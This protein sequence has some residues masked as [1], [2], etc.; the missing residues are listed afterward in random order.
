MSI[1]RA[2]SAI[3]HPLGPGRPADRR[4]AAVMRVRLAPWRQPEGWAW[5]RS[6]ARLE[7]DV[8]NEGG[9]RREARAAGVTRR[10]RTVRAWMVPQRVRRPYPRAERPGDKFYFSHEKRPACGCKASLIEV[11]TV[12][13]G[14]P[15]ELRPDYS[16]TPHEKSMRNDQRSP[17][18]TYLLRNRSGSEILRCAQNDRGGQPSAPFAPVTPSR[19]SPPWQAFA[20]RDSSLRSE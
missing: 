13:G 2:I 5:R 4:L 9:R 20:I 15:C 16:T 17:V 1:Y 8:V 11:E 12:A 14:S 7:G 6:R 19:S 10:P 3:D 18:G